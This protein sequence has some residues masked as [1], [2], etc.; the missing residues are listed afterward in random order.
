MTL[1][2]P[3]PEEA[4]V[5]HQVQRAERAL[6][7]AWMWLGSVGSVIGIVLAWKARRS[8]RSADPLDPA[9]A[10]A[11]SRAGAAVAVGISGLV[12]LAVVVLI[13]LPKV[14]DFLGDQAARD[15]VHRTVAHLEADASRHGGSVPV[16]WSTLTRVPMPGSAHTTVIGASSISTGT[17]EVSVGLLRVSG[18]SATAAAVAVLSPTGTCWAAV[19]EFGPRKSD[20][21]TYRQWSTGSSPGDPSG[22]TAAA[23]EVNP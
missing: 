13:S 4:A 2:P 6:V 22:C 11:R 12:G 14:H 10:H 5:E 16:L 8:L 18:P 20:R 3:G 9:V 1:P 17:T 15:T 19:V 21:V 7:L 23:G